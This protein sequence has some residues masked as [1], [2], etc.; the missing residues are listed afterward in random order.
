M[1]TLAGSAVAVR[2]AADA[3]SG[4]ATASGSPTSGTRGIREAAQADT[5]V[6]AESRASTMPGCH[7]A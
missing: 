6:A 2:Y 1:A 4:A 3:G 7:H 5:S